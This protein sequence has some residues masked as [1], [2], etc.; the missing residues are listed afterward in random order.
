MEAHAINWDEW[1]SYM[2]GHMSGFSNGLITLNNLKVGL[3]KMAKDAKDTEMNFKPKEI[4]ALMSF[5]DPNGD[6]ALD[7]EEVED[8]VRRAHLNKAA[9]QFPSIESF[10]F[11][12]IILHLELFFSGYF[13][14]ALTQ[15]TNQDN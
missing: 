1:F 14:E 3:K 8:A 6:N 7:R 4:E 13:S 12:P 5:M 15:E 10:L 2:D 11:Q 9:V